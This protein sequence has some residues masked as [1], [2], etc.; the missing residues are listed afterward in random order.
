PQEALETIVAA[1]GA[2][3][4]RA[5][6]IRGRALLAAGRAEE[7][8][9]VLSGALRNRSFRYRWF[10]SRGCARLALGM[11]GPAEDDFRSAIDLAP[12]WPPAWEQLA[13]ALRAR[14]DSER[15]DAAVRKHREAV[16]REER[17]RELR[18]AVFL[19]PSDRPRAMELAALLQESGRSDE[20]GRI[21][22]RAL[23]SWGPSMERTSE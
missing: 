22:T 17:V 18:R 19:D 7:A 6:E 8:E 21:R 9:R 1:P 10:W 14:G 12:W 16:D 13:E 3:S 2:N 15:V 23:E 20:A 5:E 4:P 11:S